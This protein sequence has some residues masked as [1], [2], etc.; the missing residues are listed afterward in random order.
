MTGKPRLCIAPFEVIGDVGIPE[1][2]KSIAELLLGRFDPQRF[3]LVE[4]TRLTAMLTGQDLTVAQIYDDPTVL[5]VKRLAAIRYMVVGSVMRVGTLTVSARLV[6]ASTGDVVQTAEI[7]ATDAIGLQNSLADLAAMLQM[8][9][10]E[11]ANYIAF[12]QRQLDQRAADDAAADQAALAAA[13]AQRQAELD[14]WRQQI[15]QGAG[16]GLPAN[17][18]RARRGGRSGQHQG[19][20][21][22]RAARGLSVGPPHGQVGGPQFRRHD[23]RR[24]VGPTPSR[25]RCQVAAAA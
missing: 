3:Q 1:A 9:D 4:R 10:E 21:G 19:H 11:K 7:S 20:A 18:A 15:A 6:D 23:P 12:R 14:A 17:A 24:R 25:C 16:G 8:T 13:E 5:R 2:G 22:Q